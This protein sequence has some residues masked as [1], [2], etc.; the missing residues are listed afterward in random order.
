MTPEQQEEL[1]K[2]LES[3]SPEE[4]KEFQKKQC[5]FCHI[6]SG[7]VAAKKV[8]EDDKS[9]AVLDINPANP[10]HILLMPKEHYMIMPQMPENELARIFMVAKQLS[11][12]LLK[13]LDVRG[14]NIVVANGAAAGQRAQHFM[15]HIIPRKEGDGV[16]FV[17]PSVEQSDT[18][19]EST[20]A[21]VRKWL[22]KSGDLKERPKNAQDII[23]EKAPKV[24]EAEFKEEQ[25]EK[26]EVIN[27]IIEEEKEEAKEAKKKP[28]KKEKQ[29]KAE[30]QPEPKKEEPD[31]FSEPK[32]SDDDEIDLDNIA[33]LLGG[34]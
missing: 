10:G 1:R 14:T 23:K 32:D 5:I 9:L 12:I 25:K 24:V 15:I 30:K 4:L 13:A 29:P 16:N 19:L 27:E 8:Y 2:K 31:E 11:N 6:I 18:D 20:S 34:R 22:E 26:E 17:L 28:E 3:M 33:R 7:K 21:L